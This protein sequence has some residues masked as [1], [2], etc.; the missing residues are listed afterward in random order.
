MPVSVD[1]AET[2]VCLGNLVWV[3][4][5]R[6][7]LLTSGRVV[8]KDQCLL[9]P[10]EGIEDAGDLL[11][12]KDNFKVQWDACHLPRSRATGWQC[13]HLLHL[14]GQTGLHCRARVDLATVQVVKCGDLN[15]TQGQENKA[16]AAA[17]NVRDATSAAHA[18]RAHGHSL[19][20]ECC[21]VWACVHHR[22]PAAVQT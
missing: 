20:R 7:E 8:P 21:R 19:R 12:N 22:A 14:A 17:G 3:S 9:L 4:E 10:K 16:G 1:P 11:R 6:E 5:A 2:T 15:T 13:S 18:R